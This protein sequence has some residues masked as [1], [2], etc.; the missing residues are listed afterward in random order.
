MKKVIIAVLAVAILAA[1]GVA[2]FLKG[3]EAEGVAENFIPADVLI[4]ISQRGIGNDWEKLKDSNFWKEITSSEGWEEIEP[5][6][7]E[8]QRKLESKVGLALDEGSIRELF[9]KEVALALLLGEGEGLKP[10][11]L[12]LTR[13]G[14]KTKVQERLAKMQDKLSG[15]G[16]LP[17]ETYKEVEITNLKTSSP[18]VELSYAFLGDWLVLEI[19]KNSSALK[20]SID[21]HG[22]ENQRSLANN[23]KF[24]EIR[25]RLPK[26]RA[27]L[28]YLNVE[29]ALAVYPEG[30]VEEI[31]KGKPP[32]KEL[33]RRT[34]AS[35]EMFKTIGGTT[36]FDKGLKAEFCLLLNQEKADENLREMYSWKPRKS[37]GIKYIPQGTI[38]YASS[39][40][41][42][43]IGTCWKYLQETLKEGNPPAAERMFKGIERLD[44]E[45][46]LSLED[47]ILSWI[48]NEFAYAIS[49]V[50]LEGMFPLPGYFLML[51]VRDEKKARETLDKVENILERISLEKGLPFPLR[52]GEEEYEGEEIKVLRV[53]FLEP[54]YAFV[55]DFL[56]I[57]NSTSTIK[58]LIDTEKGKETSLLEDANFKRVKSVFREK[59]NGLGYLNIEKTLDIVR[60]LTARSLSAQERQLSRMRI[61]KAALES[62]EFETPEEGE[63]ELKAFQEKLEMMERRVN[64]LQNN[65]EERLYPLLESLK[66]FKS[67][68]VNVLTDKEG[69]EQMFYLAVEEG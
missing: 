21:I 16:K 20:E 67:L 25:S 39:S 30:I 60:S 6:L 57:S 3:K 7:R 55:N 12:L 5:Q 59:S 50:D 58:K 14:M 13:V 35:L 19:G 54:G 10:Q 36:W 49:E 65:L 18:E 52:F 56:I 29:E 26:D 46:G 62:R 45:W 64:N 17:S 53:P 69:A 48:G 22:G 27:G 24:Q 32:L 8:L 44:T 68:G 23:E 37:E 15:E 28:F 11:G 61:R 63:R 43:D 51:K 33:S 9:G 66:V 31:S 47:D 41:F 40:S 1:I 42:Y 38:I 4:Y 34:S 2:L